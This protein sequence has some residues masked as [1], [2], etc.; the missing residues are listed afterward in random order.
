MAP[1][2]GGVS[3]GSHAHAGVRSM[4]DTNAKGG[5]YRS[6]RRLRGP[7][8]STLHSLEGVTLLDEGPRSELVTGRNCANVKI[9]HDYCELRYRSELETSFPNSK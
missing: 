8:L 9:V 2:P 1:I 5:T 7:S 3:S 4:I 6:Q